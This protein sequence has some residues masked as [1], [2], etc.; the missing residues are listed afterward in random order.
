MLRDWAEGTGEREHN[1]E[2]RRLEQVGGLVLQPPR[3]G[4]R[5]ALGAMAVA[6]GVIRDLLVA[7]LRA[8]QDMPAQGR[9][10]TDHKVVEGAA[11]HGR[12]ARTVLLQERIATAPDHLS[13]FEP[14]S[15]H[16]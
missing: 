16:G 4:R 6:A 5:L 13:H 1:V 14:R 15:G 9:R 11:L 2:V 8:L 7:A 10:T 3:C 12:Q